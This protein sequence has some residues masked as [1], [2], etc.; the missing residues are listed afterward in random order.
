M[1]VD[2][3]DFRS[4]IVERV[5]VKFCN[6]NI[7]NIKI[8]LNNQFKSCVNDFEDCFKFGYVFSQY[9]LTNNHYFIYILLP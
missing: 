6:V 4:T 1:K 2:F 5:T 7:K 3:F 9:R 8:L